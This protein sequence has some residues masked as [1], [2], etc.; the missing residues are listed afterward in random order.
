[1]KL[2]EQECSNCGAK[3][4][5][6]DSKNYTCPYCGTSYIVENL[7][8]KKKVSKKQAKKPVPAPAPVNKTVNTPVDSNGNRTTPTTCGCL[9]L[10]M[11][12]GLAIGL[13]ATGLSGGLSNNSN[14]SHIGI[15]DSDK[16]EDGFV[17][18]VEAVF[19]KDYDDVTKDELQSVTQ[20][21]IEEGYESKVGE[22]SGSCVVNGQNVPFSCTGSVT[23]ISKN[24]YRFKNLE[25]IV[26]KFSLYEEGLKGLEKLSSIDYGGYSLNGLVKI[27]P[28]PENITTLK[29]VY[30]SKEMSIISELPNLQ[31][32]KLSLDNV[33]DISPLGELNNLE[34]I[35]LYVSGDLKDFSVL[36]KLT[37][38]KSVIIYSSYLY[39]TDFLANLD[40]LEVLELNGCREVTSLAGLSG[41]TK[42]RRLV[43]VDC[44]DFADYAVINTL[45]NLE[46]LKIYGNRAD[47]RIQWG[48]LK[49]IKSLTIRGFSSAYMLEGIKELPELETLWISQCYSL[50]STNYIETLGQLDN[51][52]SLSFTDMDSF[53]VSMVANMDG[54]EKLYIRGVRSV[55][56]AEKIFDAPNIKEVTLFDEW[57]FMDFANVNHNASLEKLSIRY[58]EFREGSNGVEFADNVGFLTKFSGLK[59]LEIRGTKLE[60]VD[61]VRDLPSLTKLDVTNN[62]VS[63]VSAVNDCPNIVELW[64]GDNVVTTAPE[65]NHPVDVHMDEES[66]WEYK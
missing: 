48:N 53:D 16:Q 64:C 62:Y 49:K 31:V 42:L 35:D 7:E 4:K 47:E 23:D 60:N 55:K 59:E 61:F 25:S 6:I 58:C 56:N 19:E 28:Y 8:D 38:L 30:V 52:K 10:F 13:I 27:L 15:E 5:K 66:M 33:K 32:L 39:S 26:T 65:F 20:I 57:I 54:L 36:G 29:N 41:K 46:E 22:M 3:I 43:I 18:M 17:N 14:N 50:D 1:M 2:I 51:L 12:L 11:L 34:E 37:D 63:D 44:Y 21:V 40:N 24:L 9:M 45:T